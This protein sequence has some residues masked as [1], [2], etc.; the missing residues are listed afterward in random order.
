MYSIKEIFSEKYKNNSWKGTESKSGPGSALIRNK[1]LLH[2]IEEFVIKFNIKSLIDCGCGDFNWMKHFNFNLIE[3]YTGVDI[4]D[5]VIESNNKKYSNNTISFK[6]MNIIDNQISK[7]DVILCKDVLFHLSF[8]D[9]LNCLKN[10]KE[11]KS[12][13]LISTTFYDF[14]N[15]D[16]ETGNWRPI[17]LE[18]S[19]FLLNKPLLLWKNIENKTD[20]WI[21]KSIGIWKINI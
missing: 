4:V 8:E 5:S 2:L 12:T 21:N 18:T 15:K 16:I 3:K 11:S 6:Q 19:P 7:Y 14:E 1:L 10:F 17:N 9:V 20:G 13:Y